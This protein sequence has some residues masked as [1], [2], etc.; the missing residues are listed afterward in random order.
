MVTKSKS[1]NCKCDLPPFIQI[2]IIVGLIALAFYIGHIIREKLKKERI[3]ALIKG[4]NFT[5]V[6][7]PNNSLNN[8]NINLKS[9]AKIASRSLKYIVSKMFGQEYNIEYLNN[10]DFI[11]YINLLG[12]ATLDDDGKHVLSINGDKLY[13]HLKDINND[14]QKWRAVKV[15]SGGIEVYHIVPYK[16]IAASFNSSSNNP[17]SSILRADHMS[18][19]L[20]L[21][22]EHGHLSLRKMGQYEN[23]YWFIQSGQKRFRNDKF[24]VQTFT[25]DPGNPVKRQLTLAEEHQDQIGN[26]LYLIHNN[27]KQYDNIND[28]KG[29]NINTNDNSLHLVMDLHG[30]N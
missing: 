5:E 6:S 17:V 15:D 16:S 30:L 13:S 10:D 12:E 11:I 19:G 24:Q 18:K 9:C 21:Q 25:E 29:K 8:N 7:P 22:F 20:V 4:E 27:I 2:I 14:N 28:N 23:Q 26:I 3:K 1:K